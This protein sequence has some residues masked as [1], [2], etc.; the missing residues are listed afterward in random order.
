MIPDSSLKYIFWSLCAFGLAA[1]FVVQR[2]SEEEDQHAIIVAGMAPQLD[3]I[4]EIADGA[5]WRAN[6]EG[7]AGEMTTLRFAPGLWADDASAGQDALYDAF[8][9]VASLTNIVTGEQAT[10]P[11]CSLPAPEIVSEPSGAPLALAVGTP[12]ELAAYQEIAASCTIAE[13]S[14]GPVTDDYRAMVETEV[15]DDW[16]M[17]FAGGEIAAQY[18]PSLCFAQMSM[19]YEEA[20]PAD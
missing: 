8:S 2:L 11:D 12:D 3:V 16:Q 5:G 6:C 19:R 9:R 17:L 20:L 13:T 4:R 10:G 14:I 18:G 7:T 1:V 15:P